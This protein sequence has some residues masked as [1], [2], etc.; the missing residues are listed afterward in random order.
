MKNLIILMTALVL[1]VS[2]GK[3]GAPGAT[4]PA[5]SANISSFVYDVSVWVFNPNSNEYYTDLSVPEITSSVISG[6][7]VQVFEGNAS[8]GSNIW[9]ALP[10]SFQ[11]LEVTYSITNGSVRIERTM[12]N[13]SIAPPTPGNMEYKVVVIPPI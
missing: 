2:C 13:N 9:Y 12:D 8:S 7:T 5:G 4:G 1:F 3:D 11:S 10:N 6:G